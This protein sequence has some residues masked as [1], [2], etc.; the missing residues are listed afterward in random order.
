MWD[1]VRLDTPSW[2]RNTKIRKLQQQLW[3]LYV[4]YIPGID[5]LS[6]QSQPEGISVF[7]L[8]K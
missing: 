2:P 5:C 8:E 1:V 3:P 4:T 6:F 7:R